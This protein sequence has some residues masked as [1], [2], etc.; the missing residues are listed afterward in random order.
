MAAGI[1]TARFAAALAI[2]ACENQLL[3][4]TTEHFRIDRDFGIA[5]G[6]FVNGEV[7]ALEKVGEDL[8]KNFVSYPQVSSATNCLIRVHRGEFISEKTTV[9]EREVVSVGIMLVETER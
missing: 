8:L 6:V 4:N 9:Q 7:V 2:F 3:E 5:F 1:M